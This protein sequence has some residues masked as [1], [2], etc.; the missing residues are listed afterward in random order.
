MSLTF[1]D[2]NV[3]IAAARG[4]EDLFNRAMEILDDPDRQFVSSDFVKLELIPKAHYNGKIEE[5][6]F[7]ESF[8]NDVTTWINVSNDLV[9][10]ALSEAYD[11]GLSAIDSL[12]IAAAKTADVDEFITAE[13]ATSPLFRVN[14]IT[15]QSIRPM[16]I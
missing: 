15:V 14:G 4:Q 16:D 2:S 9:V 6:E 1:I 3:L 5:K 11:A 7:Y 13:R 12:H 8:F 10:T